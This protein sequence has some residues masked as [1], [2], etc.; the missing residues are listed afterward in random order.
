MNDLSDDF[1]GG[2]PASFPNLPQF[3]FKR[4][5]GSGGFGSS[6]LAY[7]E[8]HDCECV[9]K[10][11]AIE[12]LQDWKSLELF[13][14][15]A[16]ILQQLR[17]P[18]IPRFLEYITLDAGTEGGNALYLVQAYLPGDSLKDLVQQGRRFKEDEVQQLALD[19]CEILSYL[20]KLSPPLIH[21]DIKPG[22]LILDAQGEVHL[23]DFGA[24]RDHLTDTA[25]GSTIIGTFG[26]MAPEQFQGR[27]YAQSDVYALGVTLLYLLSHKEAHEFSSNGLKL[28]FR[29]EIQVSAAFADVLEKMLDPNWDMRYSTPELLADLKALRS[30]QLT[31]I[32]EARMAQS[33]NDARTQK[34]TLE[35]KPRWVLGGALA[36]M[37]LFLWTCSLMTVSP[38]HSSNNNAA[39]ERMFDVLE[40]TYQA[41]HGPLSPEQKSELKRKRQDLTEEL[42]Q[43]R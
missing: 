13:E 30:G 11:L 9:V 26:F 14:R 40:E 34:T 43:G 31:S 12:R 33:L 35:L 3:Q 16:R 42:E 38:S 19:A 17:H 7:S 21:R 32:Q 10:A 20:H 28:N 4:K 25:G 41:E 6:Y 27:A 5:I 24:V 2:V 15:E 22:N 37:G 8:K 39:R 18:R 23:I 36:L 1:S 29:R